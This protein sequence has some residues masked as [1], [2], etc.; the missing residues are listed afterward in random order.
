LISLGH[1]FLQIKVYKFVLAPLYWFKHPVNGIPQGCI[2]N[3]ILFSIIINDLPDSIP[4]PLA[5]CADDFSFLKRAKHYITQRRK[6]TITG[7]KG[8]M[9]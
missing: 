7:E 5:L 8:E 9:V 4:S 6:P 1:Y 3:T 2:V